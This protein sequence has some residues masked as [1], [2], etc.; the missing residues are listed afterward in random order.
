LGQC[1]RNDPE[2]LRRAQI[3]QHATVRELYLGRL[4]EHELDRL[5]QLLEKALPGVVSASAWPPPPTNA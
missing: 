3:V 1:F 4:T 2:A 5:S